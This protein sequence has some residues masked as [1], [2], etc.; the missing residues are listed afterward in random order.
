MTRILCALAFICLGGFATGVSPALGAFPGDNG[1]IAFDSLPRRRR[2][3]Y[4]DDEPERE[5]PSQPDRELRGLSCE[6]AGRRAEDRVHERPRDTDQSHAPQL[7]EADFEIFVMD[8]DGSD[9]TQIT[10]NALDDEAPAWSPDGKRIVFQRDFDPV[11]GQ[12]DYDIFTMRANGA[13]ERNLTNSPG[14]QDFDPDWS[15]DGRRIAFTQR[16]RRRRRDLHDEAER[17]GRTAAHV[18]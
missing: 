13:H 18:Q 5:Q 16:A 15:P 14:V 9:Q 4:L 2:L 10:F 1:K 12:I 6:L 17:L 8:A 11:R 7:P 3:R